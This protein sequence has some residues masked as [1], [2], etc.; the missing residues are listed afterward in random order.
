MTWARNGC[1]VLVMDH[2]GHGERQATSVPFREGLSA[3]LPRR[4][5]GLLLPLRH[6]PPVA[7]RRREPDGL[8]GL[9]PDA[10]TRPAAVTA[11]DR[12]G[13]HHPPGRGRGGGDPAGVTAALDPRVT[14]VAPF[15]FGGPQPD[16]A[17]PA[18]AERDFYYF[19]V[20]EWESTRCLR[21][22]ARDGFAHW[23]IVGAVAPRRLIYA[24]EFAWDR[25]ATRSG[26]GSRRSSTGT[27]RPTTWRSPPAGAT[28]GARR[29]KALTA[30]TS[31]R[32]TGAGSI[33]PWSDGSTCRSPRSTAGG[34][35]R[36]S[37]SA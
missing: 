29:R 15:N 10:R 8:D 13:P 22:G 5:A 14:A 31:A 24:H 18:D 30:T 20:P 1:T 16:F 3:A 23:L 9:G 19:G 35:R 21:L 37:C 36:T 4:P 12:Q 17:I 11:R 26:L 25:G 7:P 34:G 27:G 6:G 32:C 28:S 33:P 2:L